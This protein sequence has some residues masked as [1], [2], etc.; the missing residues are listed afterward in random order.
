MLTE[1]ELPLHSF[2]IWLP[3]GAL[4]I[5]RGDSRDSLRR[6]KSQFQRTPGTVPSAQGTPDLPKQASTGVCVGFSAAP[7][8]PG[9]EPLPTFLP[10]PN[11]WAG[12]LLL[13]EFI[14][15]DAPRE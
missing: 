6:E 15:T 2:L 11:C 13:G 3:I 1:W 4:L 14:D 5:H 10:Q 8:K 7:R 9:Q 12:L